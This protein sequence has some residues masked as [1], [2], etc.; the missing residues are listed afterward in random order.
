MDT[1]HFVLMARGLF[2][3]LVPRQAIPLSAITRARIVGV[4]LLAGLRIEYGAPEQQLALTARRRDIIDLADW[5]SDR[6]V[7]VQRA[8]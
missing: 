5:L 1:D 6:G 7:A 3:R 2:K 8:E 4:P